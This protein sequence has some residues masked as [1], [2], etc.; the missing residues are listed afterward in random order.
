M[1]K[2]RR[3]SRR[4]KIE[5]PVREER[6]EVDD[7]QALQ[8]LGKPKWETSVTAEHKEMG[9]T[10]KRLVGQLNDPPVSSRLRPGLME[11]PRHPLDESLQ[12]D[13][14][15]QENQPVEPVSYRQ[16]NEETDALAG[17]VE[18]EKQYFLSPVQHRN[19]LVQL[20]GVIGFRYVNLPQDV[21]KELLDGMGEAA[22]QMVEDGTFDQY[23]LVLKSITRQTKSDR[24]VVRGLFAMMI[25]VVFLQVIS[26]R[27]IFDD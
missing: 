10:P 8:A 17:V 11:G 18:R 16:F 5:K 25:G 13:G 14:L 1:A 27:G 20:L 22:K 2:T 6:V 26:S 9:T 24:S 3:K 15:S 19:H 4:V 21:Q 7:V 12:Q 23:C